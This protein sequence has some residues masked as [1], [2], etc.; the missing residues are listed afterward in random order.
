M[1]RMPLS[2]DSTSC[3]TLSVS[4]VNKI[5]PACTTSPSCLSHS[6]TLPVSIVQPRRGITTSTAT[7][8][9]SLASSTSAVSGS[10]LGQQVA[11]SLGNGGRIGH[12]RGFQGRTVGHGGET[13][14]QALYRRVQ[15]V[16]TTRHHLG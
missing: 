10:S 4:T 16:E 1:R 9:S 2:M 7:R 8:A 15:V 11:Y 13:A 5:S 6:A 3:A 12:H 14:I